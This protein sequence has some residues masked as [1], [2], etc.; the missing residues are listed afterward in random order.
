MRQPVWGKVFKFLAV[1]IVA[2]GTYLAVVYRQDILDRWSLLNYKVPADIVALANSAS[3]QGRGR[4]MFYVSQPKVEAKDAFNN[5]CTNNSEQSIVLGCYSAQ[6]IYVYDVTDARLNGVKEVTAAHEM[7]H[8]AYDRLSAGDRKNVDAMVQA[9]LAKISDPRLNEL[10][11][12]Y[13]Q[14]EPGELLNEMH[15]ILGTEYGGLSPQLETYY[16][17]YFGDRAKLVGYASAYAAIFTESQARISGYDTQLVALKKQIDSNSAQL[18]AQKASIDVQN[19]QLGSLRSS[20]P[21]AYNAA[22][23]G[24]NASV[25][26]YNDLAA[27][28]RKL[29][30]QY[31]DLVSRRNS[32]VAVQNGL[33]H[34]LDSN[35]QSVSSQ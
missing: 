23:P 10:I 16:K 28:T 4:D 25:R 3:M 7:L 17:Q 24:F 14:Q 29:I 15:S 26:S 35:Y 2:I 8:A 12:L 13:N 21:S 33:Y 27:K 34:S 9:Q 1:A 20:D 32:E 31:N 30:S 5:N 19:S 11:K 22:V 18:D 6:R